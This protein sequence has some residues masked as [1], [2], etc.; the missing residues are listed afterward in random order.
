LQSGFDFICDLVIDRCLGFLLDPGDLV[1]GQS[2]RA[3]S[4]AKQ[5]VNVGRVAR[6]P[7]R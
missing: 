3:H 1:F 4:F 5:F 7:V 6:S 2:H